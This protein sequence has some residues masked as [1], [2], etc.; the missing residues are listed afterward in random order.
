MIRK[1]NLS[2]L[3]GKFRPNQRLPGSRTIEIM[4]I[5][6]TR[7]MHGPSR[8]RLPTESLAPKL[9][10]HNWLKTMGRV[11]IRKPI[12]ALLSKEARLLSIIPTRIQSKGRSR[13]ETRPVIQ[14]GRAPWMRLKTFS[15]SRPKDQVAT[16]VNQEAAT[17]VTKPTIQTTISRGP[18]PMKL[19][20]KN[21]QIIQYKCY[22][23]A[24]LIILTPTLSTMIRDICLRISTMDKSIRPGIMI[25]LWWDWVAL[26]AQPPCTRGPRQRQTGDQLRKHGKSWI[27]QTTRSLH[28][29]PRNISPKEQKNGG[30]WI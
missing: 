4:K 24:T 5:K 3:N 8:W 9:L 27:W 25:S 28:L 26:Q 21:D 17:V 10:T 18:T 15:T 11:A 14:M 1:L 30:T 22:R 7:A 6:P 13:W 19:L 16:R 20:R 2:Q 23:T 12:I 29:E